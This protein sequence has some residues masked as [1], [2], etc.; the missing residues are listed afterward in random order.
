M[1]VNNVLIILRLQVVGCI[2]CGI[3]GNMDKVCIVIMLGIVSHIILLG[4]IGC[5]VHGYLMRIVSILE[6]K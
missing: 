5:I 4:V 6:R 3:G 1:Y 2:L